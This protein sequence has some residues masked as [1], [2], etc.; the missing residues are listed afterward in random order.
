[1]RYSKMWT[2]HRCRKCWACLAGMPDYWGSFSGNAVGWH[3]TVMPDAA[4]MRVHHQ[5]VCERKETWRLGLCAV[6]ARLPCLQKLFGED[7]LEEALATASRRIYFLTVWTTEINM[8]NAVAAVLLVDKDAVV[9]RRW[10][11]Y[12]HYRR[13]VN[14]TLLSLHAIDTC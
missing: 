6:L 3:L 8:C 10:R 7:A 11:G 14:N 5:F 12:N 13:A 4:L 2:S 1:M 9:Q